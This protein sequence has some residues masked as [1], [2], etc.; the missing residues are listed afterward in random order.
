[1][2][3]LEQY[4]SVFLLA[5]VGQSIKDVLA[6][7]RERLQSLL[8][9]IKLNSYSCPGRDLDSEFGGT[10]RKQKTRGSSENSIA[11]LAKHILRWKWNVRIC[12]LVDLDYS[13]FSLVIDAKPL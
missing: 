2:A 7:A 12:D 10:W 13:V 3:A 4:F 5:Y 11:V 1:M 9:K 6:R 8:T